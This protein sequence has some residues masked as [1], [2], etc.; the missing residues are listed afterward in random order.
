LTEAIDETTSRPG[1]LTWL[2][3]A[4]AGIAAVLALVG[5]H[6]VIAYAVRQREREIAVRLTVG[7]DPARITRLFLRQ[8]SW[9]LA[10]GL[11]AG[12]L[13]VLAGER[14]IANELVGHAARSDHAA[15]GVRRLCRRGPAGD[16]VAGTSCRVHRSRGRAA[17]GVIQSGARE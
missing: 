15:R 1:F 6:G 3:S 2:L 4:F 17:V 9:I 14:L 13:G 10:L 16:L 12:L 7:A 8:G 5:A 11:G